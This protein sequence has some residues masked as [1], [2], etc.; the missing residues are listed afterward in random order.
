MQ[1]HLIGLNEQLVSASQE[2]LRLLNIEPSENGIPISV[3]TSDSG[4][5]VQYEGDRGIIA[6]QEPYQFFRALGLLIEGIKKNEPFQI[7]EKP[8]Y[9]SLGVLIDCSRNAVLKVETFQKLIKHLALM[10]YS[11]VQLYTEAISGSRFA[12]GSVFPVSH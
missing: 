4:I 8:V 5:H 2:I 11:S 6:Y 9:Q 3:E 7:M 12:S 10:G 1:I